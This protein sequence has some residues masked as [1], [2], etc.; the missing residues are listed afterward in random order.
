MSPS[1]P[2]V[3]VVV[4]AYTEDRWA[5]LEQSVESVRR[6]DGSTEVVLVIDYNDALLARSRDRWDDVLVIPN[7]FRQGLSGARNTGVARSRGD[8]V[9]FL[10]DDATAAADW[11][12]LLT[13]QFAD[14][15]VVGVGGHAT[16]VWPEG[17]GELYPPE[18]LWVVGCSHRGLPTT[19]SDVRNV[20]GCSMAFRRE[21]IL[22]VGGFNPDT[23]RVGKIPLGCEETELCIRV[24]QADPTARIVL[25]PRADVRHHVTP[26]RVTWAYLRRRGFYEGVSK[27]ALSR[28]LGSGDALSSESD[29][30][31]RVIPAAVVRELRATGRGGATRAAALVTVVSATVLGYAVGSLRRAALAPVDPSVGRALLSREHEASADAPL[32]AT[33]TRTEHAP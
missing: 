22:S 29:Y 23:G 9:A 21:A 33:T 32:T 3:S 6:P 28:Q 2:S 10:D 19:T 8:V 11:L 1:S 13:I 17:G 18:L 31:R 26:D 12:D 25:E 4:C 7:E 15:S 5:D 20:I 14:P 16:P 24:R 30:L 27:A